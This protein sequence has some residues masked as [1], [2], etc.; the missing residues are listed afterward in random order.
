VNLWILLRFVLSGLLVTAL[1]FASTA[2]C[3][4]TSHAATSGEAILSETEVNKFLPDTFFFHGEQMFIES[5]NSEGILF[6]DGMH[7]LTALIDASGHATDTDDESLACLL[8]EVPLD[9]NG[10]KL[11]PGVYGIG[12][13]DRRRFVIMDIAA[14]RIFVTDSERDSRPFRARPLQIISGSQAHTYR[15]YLE[16]HFVSINRA[17]GDAK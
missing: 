9:I 3:Q 14:R 15:L 2:N 4:L 12:L 7:L 17:Y 11:Q 8:T 1:G 10:H 5:R 6:P 16:R 13:D